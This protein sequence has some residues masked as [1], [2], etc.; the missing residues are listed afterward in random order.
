MDIGDI[1][2]GDIFSAKLKVRGLDEPQQCICLHLSQD[3]GNIS[4]YDNFNYN[5]QA[6][7]N[8][9][10]TNPDILYCKFIVLYE[11]SISDDLINTLGGGHTTIF[12]R[13]ED[14]K[15]LNFEY[16]LTTNLNKDNK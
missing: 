4:N 2:I 7:I 3:R 13:E 15:L 5:I 11:P 12:L 14:L 1:K 6:D 8:E 9:D 16:N 10:I